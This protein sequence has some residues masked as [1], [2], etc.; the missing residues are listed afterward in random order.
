L[1]LPA[2]DD[3]ELHDVE[4]TANA[5]SERLGFASGEIGQVIQATMSLANARADFGNSIPDFVEDLVRSM[6]RDQRNEL[7]LEDEQLEQLKKN[8]SR[9]LND[10]NLIVASKAVYLRRDY[11]HRY[12]RARILTDVRPVFGEDRT[13]A[14]V[15]ALIVHD[16]QVVYHEGSSTKEI[17]ISLGNE[18]LSSLKLQIERAQEKAQSLKTLLIGIKVPG[19]LD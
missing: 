11:E 13:I 12:C 1:I 4:Q 16:L 14:P 3:P 9:L 15:V 8:L 5:L 19:L 18:D 6:K 17:H 7:H 10:E 2:L